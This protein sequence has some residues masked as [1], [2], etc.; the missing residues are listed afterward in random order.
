A[1][2]GGCQLCLRGLSQLVVTLSTRQAAPVIAAMRLR[3]GNAGSARG[4]A[5]LLAQAL[6]TAKAAGATGLM[7]VRADSAYYAGA[8]VSAARRAGALFSITVVA[9]SAIRAAIA[10]IADDAWAPVRYPGAVE[11]P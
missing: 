2:V 7:L 8:V 1:K 10:G 4:A 5:S 6:N 3:G 9:S 11:D